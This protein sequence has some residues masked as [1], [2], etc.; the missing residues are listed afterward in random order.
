MGT[1]RASI[2]PSQ[3]ERCVLFSV[4]PVGVW[5]SPAVTGTRPP[6]SA[7]F[8]LTMIDD[9]HAVLFGGGGT[10]DVYII[11]LTRMVSLY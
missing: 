9:C 6:P 7:G 10:K 11:D 1:L 8:S 3:C 2:L 5:S 4:T